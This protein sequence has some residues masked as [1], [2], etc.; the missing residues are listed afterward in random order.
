MAI[1]QNWKEKITMCLGT[2]RVMGVGGKLGFILKTLIRFHS[3]S[4]DENGSC[5]P[6]I[7]P[8]ASSFVRSFLYYSTLGGH[9]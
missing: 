5:L 1:S 4:P 3:Q 8:A 9:R 2:S 7:V 6:S